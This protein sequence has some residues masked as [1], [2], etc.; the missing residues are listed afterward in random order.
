MPGRSYNGSRQVNWVDQRGSSVLRRNECLRL[1]ALHAGSIGRVGI[2]HSGHAAIIPVNYRMLGSDV[3]LQL[4]PGT[5]LDAAMRRSVLSFEVDSLIPPDAWSV[6]ARGPARMVTPEA[7]ADARPAEGR[8]SV[9]EPGGSFVVIRTD[10]VSGRRFA[11]RVPSTGADATTSR[12]LGEV[13]LRAPVW[14]PRDATIRDAAMTMEQDQISSVL[15][16]DHP[17]WLVS[18]HDLIGA[19]AAGLRPG[20]PAG[21]LATRTPLW[22]TTTSTVADAVA[23]MAKHCVQHLLVI[24]A[25]GTLV[26]VL[27]R[28]EALRLLVADHDQVIDLRDWDAVTPG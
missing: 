24:S 10:V 17:A 8:P 3:V 4:G 6:L 22:A 23:M 2:V 9:R 5:I 1:L 19:L 26:G 12:E 11:L 7:I 13:D 16:G 27:S 15:L 20:D 25:D 28:R 14:L 21:D 18:E